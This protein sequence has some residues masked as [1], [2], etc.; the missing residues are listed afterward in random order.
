[1][2]IAPPAI[3]GDLT[4]EQK[5]SVKEQMNLMMPMFMKLDQLMP[6][7]FALTG[8]RDATARLILMVRR[9]FPFK[10]CSFAYVFIN[11]VFTVVLT[12][13]SPY[14][15]RNT[16]SKTSWTLSNMNSTPLHPRISAGSRIG[17]ST[18]SC[19]SKRRWRTLLAMP[20]KYP[21]MSHTWLSHP[22]LMQHRHSRRILELWRD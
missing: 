22:L 2:I 15:D 13:G 16:C 5:Q 14:L 4:P 17:C 7:F 11:V 12:L 8:N 3:L 21:A 1:M 20:H 6:F 19:G 18:I 10:S 9:T